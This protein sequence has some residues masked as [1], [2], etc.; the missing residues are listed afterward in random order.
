MIETN[1]SES[2]SAYK[3]ADNSKDVILYMKYCSA[4]NVTKKHTRWQYIFNKEHLKELRE[5]K[6]DNVYFALIGLQRSVKDKPMEICLLRKDEIIDMI[7]IYSEIQQNITVICQSNMKLRVRGT[8]TNGN[9]IKVERNR[10]DKL[11]YDW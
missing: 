3:V 6:N 7:D 4:P 1:T 8:L 2:W 10:L 5:Y 9:E 11:G